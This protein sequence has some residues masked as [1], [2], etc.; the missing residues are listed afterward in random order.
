VQS[1]TPFSRAHHAVAVKKFFALWVLS[2][3]PGIFSLVLLSANQPLTVVGQFRAAFTPAEQFIYAVSFLSPTLYLLWERQQ[4]REKFIAAGKK[5]TD[6]LAIVPR[7][8]GTVLL[9]TLVVFI[10]TA[11]GFGAAKAWDGATPSTLQR[12]LGQFAVNAAL[13]VYVY[14]VYCWY[15]TIVMSVDAE[16]NDFELTTRAQED[17]VTQGLRKRLASKG[18]ANAE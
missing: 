1:L 16:S 2:L 18:G 9:L 7:G 10:F 6:V 17:A 13:W 15:L 11:F 12:N 4:Q 5:S 3:L 8:F 14:G